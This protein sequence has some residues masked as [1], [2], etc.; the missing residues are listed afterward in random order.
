MNSL[1]NLIS[2]RKEI[3][4]EIG[5][6]YISNYIITDRLVWSE[7]NFKLKIFECHTFQKRI[8]Q[9]I[10]SIKGYALIIFLRH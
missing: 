5:C 1:K 2:I 3:K 4:E 9:S 6:T 8:N 7:V 10:S